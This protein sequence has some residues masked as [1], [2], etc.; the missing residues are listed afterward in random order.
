[1]QWAPTHMGCGVRLR[2]IKEP[3]PSSLEL[4]CMLHRVTGSSVHSTT[5]WDRRQV[6]VHWLTHLPVT[7][8]HFS[9]CPTLSP[10]SQ[11]LCDPEAS[12][13]LVPSSPLGLPTRLG[14]QG[15]QGWLS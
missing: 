2:T 11:D 1:M 12:S 13:G 5:L 7:R 10:S 9:L 4:V 3:H 8:G 15:R 6:L 14:I